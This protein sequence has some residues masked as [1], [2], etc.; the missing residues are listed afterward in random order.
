MQVAFVEKKFGRMLEACDDDD[1]D[2]IGN[3]AELLIDSIEEYSFLLDNDM[4]E[5]EEM[6]IGA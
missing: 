3:S 5:H 4:V 1:N 6:G 2:T